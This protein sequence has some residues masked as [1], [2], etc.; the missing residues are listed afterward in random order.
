MNTA[1]D[2][3]PSGDRQAEIERLAVQLARLLGEADAQERRTLEA[4][5]AAAVRQALPAAPPGPDVLFASLKSPPLTPELRAWLDQQHTEEEIVA[6]FRGLKE[7]GGVE[8]STFLPELEE[9]IGQS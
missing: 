4:A 7:Q 9:I 1:N 2:Q 3:T 8:F 6:W 5:F